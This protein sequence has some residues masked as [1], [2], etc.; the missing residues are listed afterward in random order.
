MTAT[1]TINL[2]APYKDRIHNALNDKQ[3][4]TAIGRSTAKLTSA[5]V[6]GMG[7][8]DAQK[9]RDQGRQIKEFT[10]RNL[11]DL[12]EELERNITMNGGHVH[13]AHD[14]TEANNIVLEIARNHNV[15][16]VVKSKSMV[17]EEIHLNAA[18]EYA[19]IR[20]IETDLGEYIIQLANE[21]P[22]H[23]VAP[24]MH[25]RIEDIS[26]IFQREL[27]MQPSYDAEL[28]CSIAR[29]RL[30]KEFLTADMGISGCNFAIA[31][32]GTVCIVTNEG[33]GRM[34][35]SMPRVYVAVMGIEKLVPRVEDAFLMYQLLC[36]SATGQQASVYLSMTSGPARHTT[37]QQDVDGPTEFHVV[38][39]DNGRSDMLANG[40]GEALMCI[41]CGA[42]LNVCPVYNEIGGHAYGSPYSGPIGAVISPQ[43]N[44][45]MTEANQ[46][47]HAS[48]LCGAC[49]E[50]CPVKI[51]LPKLLLDLRSDQVKN[52]ENTWFD[53]T[54]IQGFVQ[55][56]KSR[57]R[58]ESVGKLASATTNIMA[59]FNGGNIRFM[60]P[61]L[62]AWTESRNF[63]P[64]AR[65]SFRAMWRERNKA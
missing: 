58:Y 49:R 46:L 2:Y 60:P 3:L 64:L 56:M 25:K 16:K 65:K 63:P 27:D 11:P 28:M 42:C 38:L 52:D 61:P 41:R 20:A 1:S 26:E 7:A 21:P 44:I 40:Y 55:T 39:L 23:I 45:H 13:W 19:G 15:Q 31:E 51:D 62:S 6:Q 48:T 47:P 18:L 30:R 8:V 57:G 33:N 14:A 12:L 53:R 50:A 22:S 35:T 43:L 59:G 10:L 37:R 34:I 36:R 54:A 24:V 32:T 9:L 17:T 29:Q 5:R 4:R